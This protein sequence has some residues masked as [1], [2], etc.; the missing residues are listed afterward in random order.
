MDSIEK[1]ITYYNAGSEQ[2]V[3]RE[4]VEHILRNLHKLENATIYDLAEMCYASPSTI[5]RLVKKLEFKDYGDFKSQMSYALKNYRY[6]NRNMESMPVVEDQ[7]CMSQY[8]DCL[9]KHIESLRDHMKYE[10]IRKISDAFHD[11][12][13][14]M[15]YSAPSVDEERLQKSLLVSGKMTYLFNTIQTQ[16]ESLSKPMNDAVV[17]AIVPDLLEMAPMLS[18]LTTAKKEGAKVITLCSARQNYYTT[19]SDI[20]IAFEGTKTSMDTYMFRIIV[21]IIQSDYENRY[22]NKIMTKLYE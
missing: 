18:I 14:V 15:F 7:D 3:F 5:S 16:K 10:D 19:I 22:L 8:F 12:D 13:Q 21:N 20:Q 6:L 2:N 17:F 4:V 1:L 9:L 11:A